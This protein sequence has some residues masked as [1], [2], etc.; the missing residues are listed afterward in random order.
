MNPTLPSGIHV[1]TRHLDLIVRA[2]VEASLRGRSAFQILDEAP[3][4]STPI[5]VV[6]YAD[7]M[8][9][10]EAAR[11]NSW[12]P[13]ANP[14]RSSR[15]GSASRSDSSLSSCQLTSQLSA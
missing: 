11:A 7:A 8:R 4:E 3:S 5:V 12:W 13:A 10:A 2:G 1:V 6:E 9:M 14:T 15:A